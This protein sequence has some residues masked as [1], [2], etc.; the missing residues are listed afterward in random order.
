MGKQT[1]Q[2][3]EGK[4]EIPCQGCSGIVGGLS[5]DSRWEEG[6]GLGEETREWSACAKCHGR[7]S[8]TC[9]ECKGTG[10]A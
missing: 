8:L 4:G 10:T 6:R 2:K 9:P 5:A 3:C 1:C 7:G